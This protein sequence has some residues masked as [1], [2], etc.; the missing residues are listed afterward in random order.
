MARTAINSLNKWP[1]VQQ[2]FQLF[3]GWKILCLT[4]QWMDSVS[5]TFKCPTLQ[6]LGSVYP[7]LQRCMSSVCPTVRWLDRIFPVTVLCPALQ[8]L[9]D[10]VSIG[11]LVGQCVSNKSDFQ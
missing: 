7:T 4:D 8:P 3:N 10:A 6:S 2:T 9:D 1:P 5:P 11:P